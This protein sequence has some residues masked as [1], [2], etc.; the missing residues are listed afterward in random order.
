MYSSYLHFKCVLKFIPLAVFQLGAKS[1]MI[2]EGF[3]KGDYSGSTP[4]F[5][6]FGSLVMLV[7]T[8]YCYSV[9]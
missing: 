7:T 3:G 6:H 9:N 2:N 4:S 5:S 1:T 8:S